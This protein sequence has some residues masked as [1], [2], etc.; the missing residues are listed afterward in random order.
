MFSRTLNLLL[1]IAVLF[2]AA[3]KNNPGKDLPSPTDG[4]YRIATYN[5]GVFSKSGENTT[6]MVAAMM[7]KVL[8]GLLSLL[9]IAIGF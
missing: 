4:V 5:V 7:K 9:D 2:S 1:L 8:P 3:C 6:G